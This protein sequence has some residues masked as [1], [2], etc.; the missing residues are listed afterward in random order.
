MSE[1]IRSEQFFRASVFMDVESRLESRSFPDS[2]TNLTTL[3]GQLLWNKA[4]TASHD[5]TDFLGSSALILTHTL[6]RLHQKHLA[7]W[8]VAPFM[9]LIFHVYSLRRIFEGHE[10]EVRR[11][12][13]INDHIVNAQKPFEHL[14]H[15]THFFSLHRLQQQVLHGSQHGAWTQADGEVLMVQN[16]KYRVHS[17]RVERVVVVRISCNLMQSVEIEMSLFILG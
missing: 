3:Q 16:S 15:N 9:L 4:L 2:L 14:E 7:W 10:K 12:K 5:V 1:A 8:K 11:K 6:K 13:K 17:N